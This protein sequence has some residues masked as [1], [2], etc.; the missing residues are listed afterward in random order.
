LIGRARSGEEKSKALEVTRNVS[1]VK[2]LVDYV[3][4][5]P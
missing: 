4:V 2:R 5:R 1:G 3:E